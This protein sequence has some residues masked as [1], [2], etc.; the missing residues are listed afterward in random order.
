[1]E[2]PDEFTQNLLLGSLRVLDDKANPARL[3]LFAVGVR[4][5]FHDLLKFY[6]PDKEVLSSKWCDK[7][8]AKD[9]TKNH[10]AQFAIQG[11]LSD[12][13]IVELWRSGDFSELRKTVVK[14]ING[15]NELLHFK[16]RELVSDP[17][18]V[19]STAEEI[20]D[21]LFY[22]LETI[23]D[24]R[25]RVSHSIETHV[26][27]ALDG[28]FPDKIHNNRNHEVTQ[29]SVPLW[30]EVEDAHCKVTGISSKEVSIRFSANV[31]VDVATSGTDGFHSQSGVFPV[32]L[33]YTASVDDLSNLT[34]CASKID[35]SAPVWLESE[36]LRYE[37]EM[38][39]EI[40]RLV[41]KDRL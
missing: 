38:S 28:S 15:A 12:E 39:A 23:E 27:S 9:I 5:L 20:L 35:E 4:E 18:E 36:D 1:M 21:V 24:C 14:T 6:A 29:Y 3:H 34:L 2:L 33:Q 37:R 13:A 16:V 19:E 7:Q 32:I 26:Y 8:E 11:G 41:S 31:E 25:L 10:R 40:S 17:E 30:G 22:F